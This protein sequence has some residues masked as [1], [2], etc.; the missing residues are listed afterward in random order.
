ME[1]LRNQGEKGTWP[2]LLALSLA[3]CLL[4]SLVSITLMDSFLA[5]SFVFWLV[6]LFRRE[7]RLSVPGFFWPLLVYAALSIIAC[8]FAVNTAVSVKAARELLLYLVVP[9][10]MSAAASR[11]GRNWTTV[12]LLASGLLSSLYSIGYC[13]FTSEPGDRIQGF[14]GHYMTPAGL[15]LLF[16]C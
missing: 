1:V 6:A 8:F 9:I 7:T 15:L 2:S 11:P 5:V 4:F 16:I 14:M 12:A 10:T 3:G 13:I